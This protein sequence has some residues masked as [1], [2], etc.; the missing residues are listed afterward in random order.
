[1]SLLPQSSGATNA[2]SKA[3]ES[4]YVRPQRSI[5][6]IVMDVTIEESHTDELEI[7]E[8]PVEHGAAVTDHA[9]IKPANLTIRAGVSD[10]SAK[11]TAG[12]KRSVAAYE[13][14]RKLQRSREPFD[15]VTGK[16]VYRNML[17]SSLGVVTDQETENVLL[18]TAELR[19]ILIATIRT[20][21]VPRSRQRLAAK[22]APVADKG[23]VQTER[24]RTALSQA[25][26]RS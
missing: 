11:A 1:M 23:Q 22:T 15:V 24:K 19:E 12:D 2:L 18:F 16:R 8:H 14:L 17:I 26:G 7:T 13:A 25:F 10:A 3:P 6:G 9:Y 20:V 4:V 21:S 5:G